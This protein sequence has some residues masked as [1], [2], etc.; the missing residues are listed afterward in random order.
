[1]FLK[2]AWYVADWS[3][4]LLADPKR[5]KILDEPIAMYRLPDGTPVAMHD[6][7]PHRF[8]SLSQGKVIGD[9]LQCPYHGLQFDSSGRCVHNP[10]GDGMIVPR[11][12]QRT[13]PLVER[14]H[15]VWIWMGDA[16][17]ADPDLIP[18]LALYDSPVFQ[19]SRGYLHVRSNYQLVTDNLLDLTH[20]AFLHPF[21]ADADYATNARFEVK[22]EGREIWSNLW[23]DACKIT[24]LFQLVWDSEDELGDMRSLMRWTAPSCLALDVGVTYVGAAPEA[25][26][27]IPSCHLLTPETENSTHYF[28]MVARNRQLENDELGRTIHAGLA[29]AFE[30]EDEPMIAQVAENMAGK[31]F[32]DLDP[33]IL[34]TD[35]AAVRARRTLAKMIRE[36]RGEHEPSG[37]QPLGLAAS[38]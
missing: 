8:A 30:N 27:A 5:I 20:A 2:N 28:W 35:A 14:H 12:P 33:M 16:E 24:P 31:D 21:L 19:E 17:K 15:A 3:E 10:H 29:S 36:E 38:A 26:P 11:P 23:N 22:Q 18:D 4:F 7:C 37:S 32:W 1:M 6:V 13:Y 9:R 34:R 25:G